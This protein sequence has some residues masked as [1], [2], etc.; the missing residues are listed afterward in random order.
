MRWGAGE[1][2]TSGAAGGK[3]GPS[4]GPSWGHHFS[5]ADPQIQPQP[6]SAVLLTPPEGP[7]RLHPH[8]ATATCPSSAST[9]G[10]G[11]VSPQ[12]P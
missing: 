5:D 2:R 8:T 1:A 3:H 12:G 4:D 9:P 11:M 10:P 6:L 7:S